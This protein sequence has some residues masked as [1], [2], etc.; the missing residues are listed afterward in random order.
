MATTQRKAS[1]KKSKHSP[2]PWRLDKIW[3]LV[4]AG[5]EEVCAIHSGNKANAK[6]IVAAPELLDALMAFVE[7]W[8]KGGD[9]QS[10]LTYKTFDDARAA[11]AKATG[12]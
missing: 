1:S 5:D 6:L 8:S 2:A 10:K 9:W 11:I 4:Y 12:E 7:P 3:S